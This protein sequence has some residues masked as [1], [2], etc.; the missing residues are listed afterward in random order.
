[1]A[2]R[3]ATSTSRSVSLNSGNQVVLEIERSARRRMAEPPLRDNSCLACVCRRSP[4]RV[5]GRAVACTKIRKNCVRL[6][7]CRGWRAR[8]QLGQD[9]LGSIDDI[10]RGG[11]LGTF[12]VA[13]SQAVD[14]LEVRMLCAAAAR[15]APVSC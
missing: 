3:M 14:H 12:A 6:F 13:T 9:G 2:A 10:V 7:G 5:Q 11:G 8:V 1:M 15:S 4:K